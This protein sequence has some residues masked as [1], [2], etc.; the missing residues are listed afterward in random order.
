MPSMPDPM[1]DHLKHK[2]DQAFTPSEQQ[3]ILVHMADTVGDGRKYETYRELRNGK[4]VLMVKA[5]S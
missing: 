5:C 2:I 4:N 1:I 3:A